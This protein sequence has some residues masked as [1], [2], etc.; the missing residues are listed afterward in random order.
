MQEAP[1]SVWGRLP[2]ENLRTVEGGPV[3]E[4]PLG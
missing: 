4:H 3:N 2:K 1:V